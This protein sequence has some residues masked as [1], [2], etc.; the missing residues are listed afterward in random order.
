MLPRQEYQ[1]L[2]LLA[3]M[4][5]DGVCVC[6]SRVL[7]QEGG[8]GKS[9]SLKKN[10]QFLWSLP[11]H[12]YNSLMIKS[13][14]TTHRPAQPPKHYWHLLCKRKK[15]FS[16]FRFFFFLPPCATQPTTICLG[17]R[18]LFRS[19]SC[20]MFRFVLTSCINKQITSS[21]IATTM[22]IIGTRRKET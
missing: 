18:N 11:P 5:S 10:N 1:K 21:A 8:G 6:V 14:N 7:T 15:S 4:K 12:H 22:T 16:V 3:M 20:D 9:P 17:C 19:Q 2:H 13:T